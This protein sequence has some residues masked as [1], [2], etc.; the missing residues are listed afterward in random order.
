MKRKRCLEDNSAHTT[1]A[2]ST[3]FL[4]SNELF[5]NTPSEQCL[6]HGI[7]VDEP[8]KASRTYP[9]VSEWS[10]IL[11]EETDVWSSRWTVIEGVS[12]V[13]SL[14]FSWNWQKKR[15]GNCRCMEI[16]H[17]AVVKNYLINHWVH[18]PIRI[19]LEE[20]EP[21]VYTPSWEQSFFELRGQTNR[22]TNKQTHPQCITLA[23][24]LGARV[25]RSNILRLNNIHTKPWP[26]NSFWVLII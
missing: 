5:Y 4:L 12:N 3:I 13:C 6:S 2:Q 25:T 19:I 10:W 7:P 24:P 21:L 11:R 14:L 18:I 17:L 22:Q 26:F 16:T 8:A 15:N 9:D 20:T 23:L 1:S